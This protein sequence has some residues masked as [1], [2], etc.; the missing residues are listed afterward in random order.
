METEIG[1]RLRQARQARS[2][3]LEQ[4][5]E[6]LH[7]KPHYLQA[8]EEGR[9]DALPSPAQ[10][11]GFLRLY[12]AFLGVTL[13]P[14]EPSAAPSSPPEPET[15]PPA[16]TDTSP[17]PAARPEPEPEATTAPTAG[18]LPT[19][20]A[21]PAQPIFAELGAQLRHQREQLGLSLDE[22]ERH[23]HVRR[24]YLEAMEA[25]RFDD[26]P[27]PV[28]GRGMLLH[29][30]R[31]LQLDPD[32]LLLRFA[33]ALQARYRARQAPRR[34]RTL[35]QPTTPWRWP[36]LRLPERTVGIILALLAVLFVVWGGWEVWQV[37]A[38]RAPS[39]TPPSVLAVLFPTPSPT[40]TL[41]PFTPTPTSGLPGFF[42]GQQTGTGTPEPDVEEMGNA[43]IQVYLLA[44]QRAYLRVI[45]DGEER[46]AG[47]IIPGSTYF[48][49]GQARVELTTGNGAAIQVYYNQQDLG[50]MGR[51]GEAVTWI[52]TLT[53]MQ[54]P[55]P[56]ATPTPTATPPITPTP[57][58]SPTP[59]ATPILP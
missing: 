9:W 20:Q 17:Q 6:A 5:S 16:P 33:D 12:A 34:R 18:A 54:T 28:Q 3:T 48:F 57:S 24:R 2:L 59:T 43:P 22:A 27:S 44:R 42:L 47:R 51:F 14:T 25:G 50:L 36:A 10:G 8:L 53:G 32:P 23:T 13:E 15:A 49:G 40:A 45:V 58:P 1:Q 21:D 39:P 4:V 46:F 41:A 7:I 30:A 29:Y 31:F 38:Q 37:R 19:T 11:R 56:V 26:L 35:P 55:T 52:F